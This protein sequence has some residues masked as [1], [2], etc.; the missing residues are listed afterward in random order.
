MESKKESH[1]MGSYLNVWFSQ[2][3]R[4]A[5]WNHMKNQNSFVQTQ[6]SLLRTKVG[7]TKRF[8]SALYSM[9]I[10]QA[11]RVT[12]VG[13]LPFLY[14][15]N[16]YNSFSPLVVQLTIY[17]CGTP[18][19]SSSIQAHMWINPQVI[20]WVV[21]LAIMWYMEFLHQAISIPCK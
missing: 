13:P 21:C 14:Y 12:S 9:Q 11:I 1:S 16:R 18:F 7:V 6:I 2:L 3:A 8:H 19:C 5:R 20:L 4:Y 10:K 15:E 17:P